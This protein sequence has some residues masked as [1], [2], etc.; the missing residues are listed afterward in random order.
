MSPGR[1]LGGRLL[2]DGGCHLVQLLAC[3]RRPRQF[4]QGG[5][6]QLQQAAAV[7]AGKE[8][9]DVELAV[10]PVSGLAHEVL[11]APDSG[12]RALALP[13]G[14]A[15]VNKPLVP[16][17]FN[18]LY[19]PLLDQAVGEGRSKDFAQ[20]GV[21]DG[22]DREAAGPVVPLAMSCANASTM[23][24]SCSRCAR[25]CSLLL[26]EC[27]RLVVLA[28]AVDK[29]SQLGRRDGAAYVRQVRAGI[30]VIRGF[31]LLGWKLKLV[32]HGALTEFGIRLEAISRQAA[33]WQQWF[34][35]V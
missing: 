17:G 31:L 1:R 19:Q 18:V 35:T 9:P 5:L 3:G 12:L 8:G 30:E 34:E 6:P 10:P 24:G 20:L 23:L 15:V 32:S 33:R 11:Q 2:N 27:L 21:G 14:V 16:P 28:N 26:A 25:L 22:K 29:Q 7:D 4:G 13:V